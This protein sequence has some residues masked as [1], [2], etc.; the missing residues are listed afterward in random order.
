MVTVENPEELLRRILDFVTE[1]DGITAVLQTGS[2]ARGRRVDA[3]S[4]LDIELIGPGATM[5]AGRDDWLSRI[6]PTLVSIHLDN[7]GP[8]EFGWPTCLAVFDGGRKIDFLLAT[9][10][11]LTRMT[12]G[13]LDAIYGRGYL[14]HLDK[15]GVTYAL[16]PSTPAQP[17]WAP[18]SEREFVDG[19]R[20][21]W[22]EATQVPIYAARDDLWPAM[23]R[24]AELRD[25]LLRM[26]EWHAGATSGGAVDTWYHGHHLTKWVASAYRDRLTAI[27]PGYHAEEIVRALRAIVG[28]Y[29][30]VAAATGEALGLPVL[31]LHDRVLEHI[32]SVLGS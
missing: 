14:V 30:D 26:L 1:R 32:G 29:A 6:G 2:R 17:P 21:F 16:P 3:F 22:F 23:L 4:D 10:S 31:Q 18:P 19:Q 27:F 15:T 12:T 28:L 9:E 5:L 20:E 11:R 24:L 25:Q 13:G 7:D 8:G